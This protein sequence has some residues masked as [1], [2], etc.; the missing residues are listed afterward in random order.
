MKMN[1]IHQVWKNGSRFLMIGILFFSVVG[2]ITSPEI[3]FTMA[4]TIGISGMLSELFFSLTISLELWVFL[5]LIFQPMRGISASIG[6]MIV[7]TGF[8]VWLYSIGFNENCGCFG[9]F[10]VAEIGPAKILQNTGLI[11]LL[12]GSWFIQRNSS[13]KSLKIPSSY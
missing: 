3:F 10:M 2:K 4:R 9:E 5:L 1:H 7:F 13:E 8:I 11:F 12:M 6:I